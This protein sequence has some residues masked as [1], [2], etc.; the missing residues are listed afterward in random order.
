MLIAKTVLERRNANGKKGG[1]SNKEE[2][3]RD[4]SG[5]VDEEVDYSLITEW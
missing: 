3:L 4:W 1:K 2:T 5:K